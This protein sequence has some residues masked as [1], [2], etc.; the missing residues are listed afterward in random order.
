MRHL[1][2]DAVNALCAETGTPYVNLHLMQASEEAQQRAIDN[3]TKGLEN[4]KL[5]ADSSLVLAQAEKVLAEARKI[6][7]AARIAEQKAKAA[8]ERRMAQVRGWAGLAAGI[9]LAHHWLFG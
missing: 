6:A 5:E 1:D 8:R 9:Y 2:V 7:R 4:A 3:S